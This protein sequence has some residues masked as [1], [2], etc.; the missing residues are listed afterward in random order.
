MALTSDQ[1]TDLRA[2][3]GDSGSAFTEPELQRLWDRV[4]NAPN[5]YTR[6]R[7]TLGLAWYQIRAGAAKFHDYEAGA[8]KEKME[9]VF[10]HA[11]EMY[12]ELKPDVEAAMSQKKEFVKSK[13]GITPHQTRTEP[14]EAFYDGY[15]RRRSRW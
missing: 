15:P 10:K 11:T 9:Q 13:V 12:E 4:S 14:A 6:Y 1:I 3:L 8:I 7:A 2:D 5:D